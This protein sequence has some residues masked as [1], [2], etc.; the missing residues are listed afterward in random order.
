[1]IS[2]LLVAAGQDP[3]GSYPLI[4]MDPKIYRNQDAGKHA[5]A[6][7]KDDDTCGTSFTLLRVPASRSRPRT[8][9]T[10][11]VPSRAL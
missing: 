1:M 8:S 4:Q 9:A 2:D 3:E 7:Y 6:V 10:E 11:S 5:V